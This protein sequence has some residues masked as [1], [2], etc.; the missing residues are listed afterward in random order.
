MS[1]RYRLYPTGSQ[2]KG[3]ALHCGD[4]RYVWNLAL[5]QAN[6]YRPEWGP[7]P[8]SAIR[9]KQLGEARRDSWLG[10]GSSSVQQQALR[11]FDVAMK[12]WWANTHRRPTWRKAGLNEGFCV[13]DVKV[14]KLN[15]K[16]A[17]IYVPKVGE[18]RFRLSRAIPDKY[19]MA[20]I[21]LDRAMRWHVSFT[22]IPVN[23]DRRK[24]AEH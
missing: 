20:R 11:D 13:R 1:Q 6:F 12:N 14:I 16:W 4:A 3:L 19:G 7:T 17:K 9:Y 22:S 2:V 15:S 8:S 23:R 21:T 24:D 5:E 18:V 10:N